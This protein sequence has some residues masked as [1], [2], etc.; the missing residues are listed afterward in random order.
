[1]FPATRMMRLRA[2]DALRSLAAESHIQ[3]GKLVMPVFIDEKLKGRQEIAS[4][5]GIFR[6]GLDSVQ[7][8]TR[9]L[10]EIGVKSILLFGIPSAKDE[11]GTSSHDPEGVIQ[12]AV[13]LI[14]N[15]YRGLVITDLCLCE[16]TDHGHCGILKNG[17]IDGDNTLEVY[18]K[19]AV[20][21]ARA[22]A[23]IIAPSGMIDGQVGAIRDALD[24]EGF[25]SIPIMSYSAKYA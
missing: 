1:M 2:T 13:P 19:I 24:S 16:Y 12:K 25:G 17:A 23:D 22:G 10:G 3:P 11:S 15:S 6:H 20:S 9:E 8:Y 5:P 4:M 21:Y 14:K 18:R 7:E